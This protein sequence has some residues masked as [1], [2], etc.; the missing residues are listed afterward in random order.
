M[1][2]LLHT[3]PEDEPGHDPRPPFFVRQHARVCACTHSSTHAEIPRH[4]PVHSIYGMDARRC[5]M[6][7]HTTRASLAFLALLANVPSLSQ[8]THLPS[9]FSFTLPRNKQYCTH[10]QHHTQTT[11]F[12][13]YH[14]THMCAF[15]DGRVTLRH[16]KASDLGSSGREIVLDAQSDEFFAKHRFSNYG[17]VGLDVKQL[18]DMYQSKSQRHKHAREHMY[19]VW[20]WVFLWVGMCLYYALL[21][22][23]S[24]ELGPE[25]HALR[26]GLAGLLCVTR[27]TW[28]IL[29]LRTGTLLTL[30]LEHPEFRQCSRHPGTQRE[31]ERE[32]CA[33]HN[34]LGPVM[35]MVTSMHT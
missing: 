7:C 1:L 13:P 31:L 3:T 10:K 30:V 5:A 2:H 22:V 12:S 20:M 19:S 29:P 16:T 18:L 14:H 6:P 25:A 24:E 23:L 34:I 33:D 21:N 8:A 28:S 9:L 26:I 32:L 4:T 17:D 35:I 27:Q 11:F 15:Q